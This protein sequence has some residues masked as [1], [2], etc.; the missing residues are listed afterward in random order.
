MTDHAMNLHMRGHENE[1]YAAVQ[2][3]P[4]MASPLYK[5]PNPVRPLTPTLMEFMNPPDQKTRADNT[6]Y[7]PPSYSFLSTGVSW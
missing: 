7:W 4:I 6:F 5:M 3:I 1:S 2:D